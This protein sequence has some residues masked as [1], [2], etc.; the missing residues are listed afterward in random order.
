MADLEWLTDLELLDFSG[1]N[2]GESYFAYGSTDGLVDR[3]VGDYTGL[4]SKARAESA[5]TEDLDK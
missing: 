4:K 2:Y 3:H 1:A 5:E